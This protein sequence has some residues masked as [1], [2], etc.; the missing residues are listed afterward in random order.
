[1]QRS[2][3]PGKARHREIEAAPEEMNRADFAEKARA[4]LLEDPVRLTSARQ[5]RCTWYY[6]GTSVDPEPGVELGE[7]SHEL[8]VEVGDRLG[9]EGQPLL[10][11]V[12]RP[13]EQRLIDEVEIDL[14]G[15]PVYGIGEVVRPRGVT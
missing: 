4:E 14:E 15:A 12:A 3:A 6:I 5:K 2:R 9:S 8:V 10:A 7:C 1:V 13:D 11:A